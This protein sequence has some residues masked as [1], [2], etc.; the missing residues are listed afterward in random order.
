MIARD[1]T[2]RSLY[3]SRLKAERDVQ[4]K[5]DYAR[6]E[7]REEGIEIGE[8]LG[9]VKT[10]QSLQGILD[11]SIDELREKSLVELNQIISQ[12]QSRL[13]HRNGNGNS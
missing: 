13:R 11:Y 12:L 7:G 10:L 1:P 3:E 8:A 6:E 5:E 9:S 2:Q 4:A